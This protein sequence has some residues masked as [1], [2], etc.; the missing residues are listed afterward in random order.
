[1]VKSFHLTTPLHLKLAPRDWI[2]CTRGEGKLSCIISRRRSTSFRVSSARR[3]AKHSISGS[4]ALFP[5]RG[6]RPMDPQTGPLVQH[7]GNSETT[8]GAFS[9]QGNVYGD[10]QFNR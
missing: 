5:L 9:F 3:G 6:K 1:M 4:Q 2:L 7:F 10:I 8:N